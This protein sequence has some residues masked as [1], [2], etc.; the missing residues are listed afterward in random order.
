MQKKEIDAV[1]FDLDGVLVDSID[2]WFYVINDTINQFGLKTVTKS[3][4]KKEFGAPI[5]RDVTRFY[6]GKTEKEVEKAYNAN[7]NK[8]KKYVKLFPQS[9]EVLRKLKKQKIKTGLISNST[10]IIV[11]T[12][13]NSFKLNEYFDVVVTMDDVKRRKPAPDMVLKACRELNARP[14]NTILVGDTKNDMIAG[15]RAGCVTVGYKINGDYK[16]KNLKEILNIVT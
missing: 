16:I 10:K 14:K 4:F 15:K 13:L 7:F 8:R 12:I 2:A 9:V 6:I 5:E 1:L 11:T 3:Q